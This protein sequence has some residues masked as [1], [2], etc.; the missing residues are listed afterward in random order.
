MHR[1]PSD[2]HVPNAT[3]PYEQQVKQAHGRCRQDINSVLQGGGLGRAQTTS[4]IGPFES[5]RQS[6]VQYEFQD[7][8]TSRLE[9]GSNALPLQLTGALRALAAGV[10]HGRRHL[11]PPH[12]LMLLWQCQLLQ[13][14]ARPK[15]I[16]NAWLLVQAIF[17]SGLPRVLSQRTPDLSMQDQAAA[18]HALQ[19]AKPHPI[20]RR[21]SNHRISLSRQPLQ[22]QLMALN[23]SLKPVLQP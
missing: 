17:S 20:A 7:K 14:P 11:V 13:L 16:M 4:N 9:E 1:A 21:S 12:C 8:R 18:K 5:T 6:A 3:R 2:I 23:A 22:P 10:A 19:H 15:K